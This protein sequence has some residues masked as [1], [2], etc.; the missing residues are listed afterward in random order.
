MDKIYRFCEVRG[1]DSEEMRKKAEET[2]TIE[3]VIS[4]DAKD[5]HG[6]RMNMDNWQLDNFN[7]NPI[8]GYQHNV[9]GGGLCEPP[10]PDDVIGKGRAW[11]EEQP[12]SKDSGKEKRK[13]LIGSVTFET[14]DI[15]TKAEKIFRKVLFG[16][17]RAASVGILPVGKGKY[18][19]GEEARGE[20]NE[21]YYFD[22]Q[23]LLEFSI[24]NLPSNTEAMKRDMTVQ[25]EKGIEYL[26]RYIQ[27][28]IKKDINVYELTVKDVLE[29][30]DGKVENYFKRKLEIEENIQKI[31]N[32]ISETKEEV[33]ETLEDE[34]L[35]IYFK[36]LKLKL[37]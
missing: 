2:R 9:Y 5:R 6:T 26:K 21:T 31:K 10:N 13:L 8:V 11:I 37:S 17:L 7:A 22:G 28:N 19:E 29:I 32:A 30:L 27:D 4:S 18:G 25:A 14:A 15:N 35:E 20:V 34:D 1:L 33:K 12:A 3:F 36:N 16:S 24:V 23:E